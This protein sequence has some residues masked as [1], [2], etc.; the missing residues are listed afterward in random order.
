MFKL[1]QVGSCFRRKPSFRSGLNLGVQL[2]TKVAQTFNDVHFF[3]FWMSVLT[4]TPD[5][6]DF[7]LS[8]EIAF[9]FALRGDV[10]IKGTKMGDAC[11]HVYP[12]CFS[13][14]IKLSICFTHVC[15]VGWKLSTLSTWPTDR[16][17]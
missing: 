2:L 9:L 10:L 1:N 4:K 8:G 11:T 14:L 12:I 3:V 15:P 13:N 5:M 16:A 7:N 17:C 6:R